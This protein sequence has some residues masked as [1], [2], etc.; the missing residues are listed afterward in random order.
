[1]DNLVEAAR[2]NKLSEWNYQNYS[3]C[4]SKG[5]QKELESILVF[6]TPLQKSLLITF[7]RMMGYFWQEEES[8]I[9]YNAEIA[10]IIKGYEKTIVLSFSKQTEEE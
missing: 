7:L 8:R 9:I 6:Y 2:L 3:P 4:V 10:N 5:I 1:V